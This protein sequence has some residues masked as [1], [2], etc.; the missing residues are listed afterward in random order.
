MLA[1]AD[2]NPIN[3]DD[4]LSSSEDEIDIPVHDN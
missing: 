1:R 3:I 4:A 2:N